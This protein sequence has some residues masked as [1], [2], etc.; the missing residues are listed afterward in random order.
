MTLL[1][2]LCAA[3]GGTILLLQ[4]LL[5]LVGLGGHA[6]VGGDVGHDFGG[7]F[8]DGSGDFHSGDVH[9]EALHDSHSTD[10]SDHYDTN[11]LF[12]MLSFRAV[13]AALAF[14]GLAG[15]AAESAEIALPITVLIAVA[16][17]IA[18]MYGV[19]WMMRGMQSL[20]AD[21]TVRIERAIGKVGT[22]YL[23]IPAS[24]S[25]SGKIQINLQNRTMEYL[26]MTSGPEIPTGTEVEIVGV[27]SP[28][29]VAVLPVTGPE[30]N[31][32]S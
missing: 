31:P 28:T 1:F 8:H 22:V 20:Q 7:G 19:Y 23:R 4:F 5:G 14:F 3:L 16:A 11:W 29:T 18:A 17:G 9:T 27:I 15:L 6:D 13:V 32:Q 21:G 30:N 2:T 10:S 24:E 25:E 12:R 26:A